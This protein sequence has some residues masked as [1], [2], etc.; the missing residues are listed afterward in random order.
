[1]NVKE[2]REWLKQFPDDTKVQVISEEEYDDYHRSTYCDRVNLIGTDGYNDYEYT[3][4]SKNEHSDC[5][6]KILVLGA[7]K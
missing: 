3:D 1:M 2:M 5:N 7:E 6:Y 4:F